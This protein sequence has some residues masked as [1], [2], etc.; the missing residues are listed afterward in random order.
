M[1]SEKFKNAHTTANGKERGF[2]DF[3]QL[4]TLWFNMGTLCNLQC[5]NCYLHS[6][7]NNNRLLP[8]T[9]N[10]IE[11][12][13]N[14][15]QR[16]QLP[17]TRI[18]LTGG[19]PFINPEI[20]NIMNLILQNG[21]EILILTNATSPL[22]KYKNKLLALN[23]KFK[24]KIQIRVSLDHYKQHIHDHER[25]PGCFEKALNNLKWLSKNNF[26]LSIA[27]RTLA[28]DFVAN[29]LAGYQ[30]LFKDQD[31]DLNISKSNLIFFPEMDEAEDV[32]EVTI[33]CWDLLNVSPQDQMCSKER[34]VVKKKD[35]DKLQV[36]PCT[37]L[38]E[39]KQFELGETLVG[40]FNRVYLNH[41]HCAQFCVFGG[42]SCS[43]T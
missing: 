32:P 7:P 22:E 27:G 41:P 36:L 30:Q 34:M 26:I 23:E 43:A 3:T 5:R 17:V 14:E 35:S 37:I 11:K 2:I 29:S 20:I 4:Q 39:D 8:I 38:T 9:C 21:F 42:C 19:E 1:R 18:G 33:S 31:I 6:S 13:I 15:I 16:E 28:N 10:E 12:Y 25:G 24:Q 40:S